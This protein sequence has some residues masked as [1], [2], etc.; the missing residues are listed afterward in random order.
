MSMTG[1]WIDEILEKANSGD[2]DAQD[3]LR[4]A[5]LWLSPEEEADR[6]MEMNS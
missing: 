4:E 2:V 1:R 5:G 3:T 6:E